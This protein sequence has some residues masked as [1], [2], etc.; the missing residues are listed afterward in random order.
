MIRFAFVL[1]GAEVAQRGVAN[2]FA[3]ELEGVLRGHRLLLMGAEY[4]AFNASTNRG[5]D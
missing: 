4:I 2:G 3:F 1:G 5:E